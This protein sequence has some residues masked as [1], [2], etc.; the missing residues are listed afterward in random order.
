MP[1][2]VAADLIHTG[3]GTGAKAKA[4]AF[5]PADPITS[6]AVCSFDGGPKDRRQ[7]PAGCR[8]ALPARIVGQPIIGKVAGSAHP[9]EI[10]LHA[11]RAGRGSGATL[12]V[13][14]AVVGAYEA[15]ESAKRPRGRQRKFESVA[16][17]RRAYNESGI[18]S[19]NQA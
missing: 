7:L 4:K 6:F 15:W 2:V 8:P 17:R 12:Q 5:M 1:K 16:A 18:E 9:H 13:T 11:P 10:G 14:N 19:C 3:G